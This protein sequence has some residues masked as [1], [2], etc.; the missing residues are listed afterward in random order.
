MSLSIANFNR[1]QFL[2][3]GW[4][5]VCLVGTYL[6]VGNLELNPIHA[7]EAT[8]AHILGKSLEKDPYDFNPKHF[9]GP[10]LRIVTAPIAR[11][12]GENSWEE[13]TKVS[14]RISP[15][16]AGILL[17]ITPLLFA[18]QLGRFGSL[19]S[20]SFIS[21][22]PLL[23]Y[24]NRIYIHESLLTL[25]GLLA[26][27]SIMRLYR[28]PSS[29]N[30][31]ITGILIGLML[32]TKVTVLISLLAWALSF[33][34]LFLVPQL[35]SKKSLRDYLK[36][37]L[38]II[39][40]SI[41]ISIVVYTNGLQFFCGFLDACLT[42]V[43]Y[44]PIVGHEKAWSYYI[45]KLIWPKQALG[46]WWSEASI[47]IVVI[48]T[49]VLSSLYKCVNKQTI[50]ILIAAA[51]HIFI[52]SLISYKTPW[53]MLL[54]WA[55]LCLV[56]GSVYHV[57]AES[58][59]L[60]RVG[61]YLLIVASLFYQTKQSLHAVN[62]LSNH[63]SNPYAYVPTT[64]DGQNVSNWLEQIT[65]PSNSSSNHLVAVIGSDYWPMP[66]YLRN[67]NSVGYWTEITPTTENYPII[68]SMPSSVNKC[69]SL[70]LNTHV[71]LPRSLRSNVPI[72]L[73]LRN[74]Y[75][76]HWMSTQSK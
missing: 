25:F 75:W 41:F 9:H 39:I 11:I 30:G 33:I 52:Y 3:L 68:F 67:F 64:R 63:S 71:K 60:I 76:E 48:S 37:L 6:R 53:L 44:E 61:I 22:S 23:V 12:R 15:V 74:D 73:Y 35:R 7:D 56:T 59:T 47:V 2:V 28:K 34:C 5:I 16:I 46:I 38:F 45:Y 31:V 40:S 29:I 19:I 13:L 42:F 27:A 51:I 62:H 50:I 8:G 4:I 1:R 55:H 43:L 70:L 14:L 17:I 57:F 18:H 32:T 72:I 20:A 10:M 66:W 49:L 26:L 54:P 21:S 24:Y 69:D 58:K 36:P 65:A